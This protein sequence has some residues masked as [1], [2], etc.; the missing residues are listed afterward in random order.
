MFAWGIAIESENE[1][2]GF[3]DFECFAIQADFRIGADL[4]TNQRT[5]QHLIAE[6]KNGPYVRLGCRDSTLVCHG[7]PRS[8]RSHDH[9]EQSCREE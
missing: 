1:F 6:T 3:A 5:L 8:D 2:T 4:A 9:D 7:L